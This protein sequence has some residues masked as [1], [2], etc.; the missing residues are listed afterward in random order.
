MQ[1]LVGELHML[2]LSCKC[3]LNCMSWRANIIQ[4]LCVSYRLRH[5]GLLVGSAFS[6]STEALTKFRSGCIISIIQHHT[7]LRVRDLEDIRELCA[8]FPS[9]IKFSVELHDGSWEILILNDCLSTL[10]LVSR[11]TPY[12]PFRPTKEDYEYFGDDRVAQLL[13]RSWF[14]D[15]VDRIIKE[16]GPIEAIYYLVLLVLLN[17]QESE[18]AVG[19][20]CDE[21]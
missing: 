16:A 9:G 2:S 15:R 21:R 20:N 7:L 18:E 13:C 5:P 3:N 17:F 1:T 14:R 19:R 12:D 6:A 4:C 8:R 10:T 11:T